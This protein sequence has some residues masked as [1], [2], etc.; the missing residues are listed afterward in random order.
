MKLRE[1]VDYSREKVLDWKIECA[2]GEFLATENIW[3]MDGER[4]CASGEVGNNNKAKLESLG[5]K[6]NEANEC[7]RVLPAF[8][9][10]SEATV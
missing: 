4:S 2:Y 1:R 10:H 3:L 9:D 6:T 7:R 8:G 5:S